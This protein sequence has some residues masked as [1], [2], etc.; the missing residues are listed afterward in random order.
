MSKYSSLE[1]LAESSSLVEQSY[2]CDLMASALKEAAELGRF[3]IIY[4]SQDDYDIV[5]LTNATA[6]EY[7]PATDILINP[8]NYD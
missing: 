7:N 6:Y 4:F 1:A 3:C 8:P 2:A 5:D